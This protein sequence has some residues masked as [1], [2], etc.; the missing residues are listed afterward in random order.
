MSSLTN[1]FEVRQFALGPGLESSCEMEFQGTAQLRYL[2]T[3]GRRCL[4]ANWQHVR[5]CLSKMGKPA[6]S[7]QTL[8]DAFRAFGE[9]ELNKMKD[10]SLP[11]YHIQQASH[12]ALFVPFGFL[13]CESTLNNSNALGLRLT[14]GAAAKSAEL[15]EYPDL[16]RESDSK[17]ASLIQMDH[18]ANVL[19]ALPAR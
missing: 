17:N 5:T 1:I 15:V 19:T 3:G 8:W 16:L 9:A 11:I 13:V 12:V 18:L 7:I 10:L 14:V 6:D 4:M 2:Y